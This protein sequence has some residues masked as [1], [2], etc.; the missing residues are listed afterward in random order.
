MSEQTISLTPNNWEWNHHDNHIWTT[1]PNVANPEDRHRLF[2]MPTPN[3]NSVTSKPLKNI[4]TYE[5][6][7]PTKDEP[8]IFQQFI[9]LDGTPESFIDFANKFGH[10]VANTILID[11]AQNDGQIQLLTSSLDFWINEHWKF[12]IAYHLWEILQDPD[13]KDVSEI[14]KSLVGE[15][16]GQKI[17]FFAITE[18]DKWTNYV[19]HENFSDLFYFPETN[20]PG[21]KLLSSD[22]CHP[23]AITIG[24]KVPITLRDF[25]QWVLLWLVNGQ[26][27]LYP[28]LAQLNYIKGGFKQSFRPESLLA[29]MWYNFFQILTG[30]RII[31]QCVICGHWSDLTDVKKGKKPWDKHRECANWDAV[32]KLRKFKDIKKLISTGKSIKE[33][34]EIVNIE[35]QHIKRWIS[36]EEGE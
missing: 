20:F 32:T 26:L 18:D 12:K 7:T 27:K 6:I 10:L 14:V 4:L 5:H 19:K 29:V 30:E 1:I 8:V 3:A 17:V 31:R 34:S 25:G 16:K 33:V 36:E 35:T 28:T 9:N 24:H 21:L 2:L 11:N 13:N 23:I 22:D 15:S